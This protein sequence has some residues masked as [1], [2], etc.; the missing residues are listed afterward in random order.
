MKR[1]LASILAVTLLI[2]SGAGLIPTQAAEETAYSG[3]C[4]ENLTWA[5]ES[6]TLTVSGTGKMTTY[7]AYGLSYIPESMPPVVPWRAVREEILSVVVEE[8]VATIGAG[9][10]GYCENLRSVTLPESLTSIGPSAFAFCENLDS[11]QIPPNVTDINKYAFLACGQVFTDED[12]PEY[13]GGE[14]GVLFSEGHTVLLH[15]PVNLQ[16]TSYTIPNTVRRIEEYAFALCRRLE[17]VTV[18]GSV[19]NTAYAFIDCT[20]LQNAIIKK[21]VK[22]IGSDTFFGCENL[23]SVTLPDGLE[24]IGSFAF[25]YTAL[26]HLHIPSSVTEIS[27]WIMYP[28]K[29]EDE[30]TDFPYLLSFYI[31]SDTKNCAAKE[32]ADRNEFRFY[33]CR[34]NHNKITVNAHNSILQKL[35]YVLRDSDKL[36]VLLSALLSYVGTRL[37]MISVS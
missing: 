13:D 10:F 17:T 15:Y 27:D 36:T 3:S 22:T 25:V 8:G 1:F 29:H 24:R 28:P 23:H 2:C 19:E 35:L 34:G 26:D 30:D 11:V 12:N 32:F 5:L 21:G 37:K 16:Q 7:Q 14:D 33:V 31:C 6:G 18:P 4:G 20:S 9:A